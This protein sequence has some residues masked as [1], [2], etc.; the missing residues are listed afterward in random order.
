VNDGT[1]GHCTADCK[2][3]PFCGDGVLQPDSEEC[4]DGV[5]LSPYGGCAPGCKQGAS[6][7][8]GKVDS[9][10]GEKCDDGT[11]DGGY[12][13]CGEGCQLG[14]AAAT[15]SSSPRKRSATTATS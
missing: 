1:Y 14:P 4:D 9:L 8:D 7:G 3:G 6:C 5:N 10:F 12:N 11:N 15:A 2:F 13:E